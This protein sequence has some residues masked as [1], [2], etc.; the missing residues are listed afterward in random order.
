MALWN[1]GSG[2]TLATVIERTTTNLLLPVANGANPSISLISGI[3]PPGLRIEGRYL[4]G[5]PFEV[6]RDKSFEFVLRAVEG[7][8]LEDRTFKIIITGPDTPVWQTAEGTLPVGTNNAYFVLD[9]ALVDFQLL[10]TDSDLPA[11]DTL[12]YYIG[13]GEGELPPGLSMD[14]TGR[15]TGIVEPLLSLELARGDG[16]YD[17]ASY[18]GD[19]FDYGIKSTNGFSSYYYDIQDYDYSVPTRALKKLNRYYPFTV[20]VSDGDEVVKRDFIIYLVGDDYLRADNT[21]MQAG[22]GVFTADNTYLRNPVWL[23]P[24]DLGYRRANNYVTLYLDVIQNDTLAGDVYYSLEKFNLDGTPSEL[25]PGL[26]IDRQIGEIVGRIPYQPAITEEYNFTIKAERFEGDLGLATIYG[27][28]YEDTLLG[29]D[30]FKI[31]NLDTS[32]ADGVDDL[33]ELRG[34]QIRIANRLYT[35]VNVDDAD[36]D[37]YD[38]I[39]LDRTLSPDISLVLSQTGTPGNSHIFVQRLTESER[40]KYNSR[41]LK[42][43]ETE[44]Y[45]ITD[46]YPYIEYRAEETVGMNLYVNPNA[47]SIQINEQYEL[48]EYASYNGSIY[49]LTTGDTIDSVLTTSHTIVAET[50]GGGATVLDSQGNPVPF[51]DSSKWTLIDTDITNLSQTLNKTILQQ[52]L[53][54]LFP[55]STAFVT[56]PTVGGIVRNDIWSIRIPATSDSRNKKQYIDPLIQNVNTTVRLT[57]YRDNEDYIKLDNNLTRILELGRNI[58][59]AIF[60]NEFF[61]V[62]I[63]VAEADEVVDF[64]SS[65]KQFSVKIIGEI[66]ST[67]Q[68]IT[69]PDLGSIQANFVSTLS[70]QATTTVP[71]S[72]MIYTIKSGKLPNGLRLNLDGQIIGKPRQ[73]PDGDLLGLTTFD[74]QSTGFDGTFPTDTTFDRQYRFTI[75]ARDRFGLSAIER[76]FTLTILAEDNLQYSNI[77]VKPFLKPE[78]RLYYTTFVSN[79][80]IFNPNYIYRPDDPEFGVQSQ[81]KMLVY[82]GIETKEIAEYVAASAKHHKRRKFKLGEIKKAVAKFPGETETVYEVVYIDVLDPAKPAKGEV[83]KVLEQKSGKTI[84]ADS[85][86]YSVKDDNTNTAN[87]SAELGI[88]GRETIKFIIPQNEQIIIGTRNGDEGVDADFNDFEIVLRSGGTIEIVMPIADAEP[89][90][91]RP[92]YTNTIKADTNAVKVSQTKDNI[93]Y[94]SNIDNMREQIETVGQKERL[95]LPLWMRTPQGSTFPQELDYVTAIPLCFCKP[96]TADEILLNIKNSGFDVTNI[97]FDIDRYIIDQTTGNSN[98]QYILFANY[99]FNV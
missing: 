57:Q 60:Q 44:S 90:R 40:E 13:E 82:A 7:D 23:T 66:D 80:D 19:L 59:I 79:P 48:G 63:T 61:S 46:I 3:L 5:T 33:K 9:N 96:G 28:F 94:I 11:G 4:V 98:E 6:E 38:L 64:P 97:N 12:V 35:V 31:Y 42:F 99:Q 16:G 83:R 26:E 53:E 76:E 34:R 18:A 27:T 85:I 65:K 29:N 91:F 49:R 70:V 92:V 93:K 47:I 86:Q 45:S 74:Q 20:T 24:S 21:V 22:T 55:R 15:I 10:A 78:Q 25:P 54:R 58:G 1:V 89:F 30:S 81:I 84:T 39:F 62:D 51:F 2:T 88:Y 56:N 67:I 14:E 37:D 73:F 69:P 71:D 77:Y 32:L 72:A 17:T 50:D 75:E 87:G 43:S 41:T 68:W 95:Y 52:K 36:S 8:A